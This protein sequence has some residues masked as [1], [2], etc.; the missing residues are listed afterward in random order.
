MKTKSVLLSGPTIV[1]D[2]EL[3]S[4]L[5]HGADL[6]KSSDHSRI[7]SVLRHKTVDLILVEILAGDYMG[8]EVLKKIRREFKNV[9][10]IVIDCDCDGHRELLAQAFEY[11]ANDAFKKP[12]RRALI[13][14]RVNA[15]LQ[16]LHRT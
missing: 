3:L 1:G 9:P 4:L 12:Y 14:E 5:A 10:I 16:S 15:L 2:E 7:E 11:G 13:V 6:L 8:V